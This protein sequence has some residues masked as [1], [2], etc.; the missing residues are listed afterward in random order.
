MET[1]FQSPSRRTMV[2]PGFE[3]ATAAASSALPET[4]IV[5]ADAHV[6]TTTDTNSAARMTYAGVDGMGS[7]PFYGTP[8]RGTDAS[9]WPAAARPAG[10]LGMEPSR[11]NMSPN[12]SGKNGENPYRLIGR[13]LGLAL[14]LPL[15]VLIGY[16]TGY[17][18]DRA[19]GTSFLYI[20]FLL[21]GAAAGILELLRELM[22]SAGPD[23]SNGAKRGN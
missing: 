1:S 14:M 21:L 18:L 10:I 11:P 13:V 19:F 12:R 3:V 16:G 17:Y 15:C 7:V 8:G 5:S 6:L 23:P 2:S 20:V 22:K 4:L 9:E